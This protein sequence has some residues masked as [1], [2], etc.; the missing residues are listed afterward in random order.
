MRDSK[1]DTY[2]LN[3]LLDSV[4]E[5]EGW[6]ICEDGIETCIISYVKWIASPGSMHDIGC[7][8]LVHWDDTERWY[9][10]EGGSEWETCTLV[11]DSCWCMTKPIWCC[12]VISLQLKKK[13]KRKD[14]R[15]K[16]PQKKKKKIPKLT[17]IYGHG[18]CLTRWQRLVLLTYIGSMG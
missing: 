16:N 17:I 2:V 8:G 9:G 3:S 18:R 15:K 12:K 13:R 5:G 4:G 1:I 11:V 10:E 7:S 6:V 14:K